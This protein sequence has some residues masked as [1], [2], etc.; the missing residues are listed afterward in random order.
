MAGLAFRILVRAAQCKA[1]SEVIEITAC[2]SGFLGRLACGRLTACDQQCRRRTNDQGRA[3]FSKPVDHLEYVPHDDY[4]RI[5][6]N[7]LVV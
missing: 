4:F 1:G 5:S 7:V 3:K 6:V 2:R